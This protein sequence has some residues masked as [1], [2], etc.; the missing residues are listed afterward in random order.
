MSTSTKSIPE[1]S[2]AGCWSRLKIIPVFCNKIWMLAWPTLLHWF[3]IPLLIIVSILV[4]RWAKW[5]QMW[6]Q[7]WIWSSMIS[8]GNASSSWWMK[9]RESI[10]FPCFLFKVVID[11]VLFQVSKSPYHRYSSTNRWLVHPLWTIK[12]STKCPTFLW[13]KRTTR[14]FARCST[15]CAPTRPFVWWH[16]SLPCWTT[17]STESPT[18]YESIS[19]KTSSF[20][21]TFSQFRL[22]F[23]QKTRIRFEC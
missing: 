1:W 8:W 9:P 23:L 22:S 18:V 10:I 21:S 13:F 7:D 20:L 4:S 12:L 15:R 16:S 5:E 11:L 3:W 14:A 17:L 6:G 2:P 19:S